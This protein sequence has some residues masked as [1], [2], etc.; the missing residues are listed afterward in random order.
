MGT[1]GEIERDRMPCNI[2]QDLFVQRNA[3]L[4][5]WGMEERNRKNRLPLHE[6]DII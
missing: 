3:Q 5:G 6:M 2:L 4:E 1:A